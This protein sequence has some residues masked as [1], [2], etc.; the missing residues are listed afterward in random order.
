M[1]D[2]GKY[3]RALRAL[4]VGWGAALSVEA[5]YAADYTVQQWRAV[6]I[7]L[8]SSK[9]YADPFQNVDVTATFV[10]PGG[11]TL[12]RP[13][14]WD[15]GSTWKIRFAPTATGAWAMTTN[16]TDTTNA[17]LH[18]I[19][20]TI[21]CDAY[22]GPL[23]VY[24]HGF[25]KT[26]RNGRYLTYADGTPF[27]YLGDTHWILPHERFATSNVAGVASQF[28]YVVD[29]RAAQGFTVFQ[30]EPIWQPHGSTGGTHTGADEEAKANLSDGLTSADLAGFAN[31]DRKFKYV[32]DQG[33]VHANAE[34][35]WAKDP[36]NYAVY[37]D[38]YM[39]R[40]ARYWVARYGAYPVIWTIAQE[41]D[42]NMYG[43]YNSTT[44]SKWYAVGQSL[45]DNDAYAQP[46]LP[47]MENLASTSPLLSSWYTKAYQDGW[48]LQI[49]DDMSSSKILQ[50][51]VWNNVP[52]KPSVLYES[53]YDNFWTDG[54]TAL[55]AG[56]KAFQSGMYGY[57][58]GAA[59][60]WNDIYSAPGAPADYGTDFDIPPHYYW[61]YDGANQQTGNQLT[62][63]KNFYTSLAW[64]NLI[65]RFDDSTWGSFADVSRSFLATDGQDT[66]V[67]FFFASG[68]S[69]GTLKNLIPSATYQGRWFNP[70]TGAYT[71]LGSLSPGT[72]QWTIPSRPTAEDWVLLVYR[73]TWTLCADETGTCTFTGTR[74]V[75]YGSG[76]TYSYGTFTGSVACTNGVFSDPTPGVAKTC[77]YN[78]VP[79]AVPPPPPTA[80]PAPGTWTPCANEGGA[81]TFTGT[82]QV[83][84]GASGT[85]AYGTFTST[86]L[87]TN[88]IF[89]DPLPA[90]AKTC[91]YNTPPTSTPTSTPTATAT[92]TPTPTVTATARPTATPTPGGSATTVNLSSAFNVNV[93]YSDGTTFSSTGGIDGVGSAYSSTL[94]GTSLTWS[95]AGFNVGAA[96]QVNGVRNATVT[97]PAG[98]FAT[99]LLLGTAVN[100]DQASQTVRVNYTDGT[101]STFTQTFSNWL[102]ASQAV[103]GQ[104]IVSTMAY[105]NK[106]T[107]VKDN[108]AFNLYGYSFA[109]TSTKTVSSL[110]LPASNNVAILAATLRT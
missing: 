41:I 30:S 38:A 5:A 47:H 58:Y 106:S 82:R 10:G 94:L 18:N 65:P 86:V 26:S 23:D 105:R 3:P 87:C 83:R 40:V 4:I 27:F 107:G 2:T 81:C 13:A 99:L 12:T 34:V 79:A 59:G 72:G 71:S 7:T 50:K 21:Q 92:R 90:V 62:Y 98:Q 43:T 53:P 32:A 51:A 19:S 68:T 28:K 9:T 102:N 44:M 75:R 52:T 25:L 8:A 42:Q 100:G 56:Y 84:Y 74:P 109:L 54:R 93:A 88:A 85:Y 33:L 67:V 66:Y 60:V 108:R 11:T 110:V 14:F 49:Q 15:G 73:G 76:G 70:R 57:G 104:S 37:T 24:K 29:K 6:E 55:G 46:L 89:G 95:G 80:T 22:S 1:F 48:A 61:W 103:A 97:L 17:G 45:S 101:S 39:S 96:N 16:S 64:W 31:L 36:A 69:T 35:T 91:E 77:E 20:K 63:L 78:T